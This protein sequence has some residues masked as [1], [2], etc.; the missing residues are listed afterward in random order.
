MRSSVFYNLVT[1]GGGTVVEALIKLL[2]KAGIRYC[3][4]GGQAVNYYVEPLV[5]LDLDL[6]VA[7]ERVDETEELLAAHFRVRR[8]PRSLNF[9]P[10]QSDLRVQIQTDPRYG[11]F[12]SRAKPGEVLGIT[13]SVA[14]RR[15][16]LRGKVWAAWDSNP[17]KRR[18][19]LLDIARL[20]EDRPDLASLVPPEILRRIEE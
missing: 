6:A 12:V 16:V 19:D 9:T 18:K 20:I 14:D 11:D 1:D 15:D 8:F 4:I 3:V 7:T 10:E 2:D 5:S 17:D 13:M